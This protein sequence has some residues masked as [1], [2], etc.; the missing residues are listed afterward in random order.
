MA[1]RLKGKNAVVTGAAS[2]LGRAVTLTFLREGANVM[3]AD[4]NETRLREVEA[5]AA[6]TPIRTSGRISPWV[7]RRIWP[8]WRCSWLVTNP[9]LC[10]PRSCSPTAGFHSER[11]RTGH[12]P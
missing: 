2:G 7:S 4:I 6:T 8:M 10:T 3:G 1:D 12:M 5:G 9:I 11:R